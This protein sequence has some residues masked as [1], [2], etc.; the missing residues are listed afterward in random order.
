[1]VL[2]SHI[3]GY[4]SIDPVN[5]GDVATHLSDEED[6]ADGFVSQSSK[7]PSEMTLLKDYCGILA[8]ADNPTP[9]GQASSFITLNGSKVQVEFD[10]IS[11]RLKQRILEAVARE[12]HGDAAVRIIRLLLQTGK[13]DEKQVRSEWPMHVLV[14]WVLILWV[15]FKDRDDVSKRV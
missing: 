9:A 2:F 3:I 11:R 15:D 6:L 5:L 13:M 12:R 10:I 7:K 4:C 14:L 1:M 8:S